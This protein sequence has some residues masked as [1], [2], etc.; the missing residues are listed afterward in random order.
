MEFRDHRLTC[1]L[2]RCSEH[3]TTIHSLQLSRT[4]R[5]HHR[6]RKKPDSNSLGCCCWLS[7]HRCGEPGRSRSQYFLFRQNGEEETSNR[8]LFLNVSRGLRHPGVRETKF[9]DK[10]TKG[11]KERLSILQVANTWPARNYRSLH[12]YGRMATRW[13]NIWQTMSK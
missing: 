5:R 4:I 2:I 13:R 10:K 11:S 3:L 1:F 9:E 8:N 12:S 6:T 7:P